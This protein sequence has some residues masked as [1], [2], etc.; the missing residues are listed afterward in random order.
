MGTS[1]FTYDRVFDGDATTQEVPA[2]DR[3]LVLQACGPER[4]KLD[5]ELVVVVVAVV[6]LVLVLAFALVAAAV[7]VDCVG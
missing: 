1:L 2:K 3:H 5:V 6:V 4:Y 7:V